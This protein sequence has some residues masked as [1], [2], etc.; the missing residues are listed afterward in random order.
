MFG[1]FMG[2]TNVF[3]ASFMGFTNRAKGRVKL[4][5]FMGVDMGLFHELEIFLGEW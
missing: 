2:F 1:F 5:H 4:K 3:G